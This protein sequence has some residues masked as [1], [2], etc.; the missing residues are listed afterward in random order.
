[1]RSRKRRLAC[2]RLSPAVHSWQRYGK[3]NA[4]YYLV[5]LLRRSFVFAFSIAFATVSHAAPWNRDARTPGE[6][7]GAVR[8]PTRNRRRGSSE[9]PSR[10]YTAKT[11]TNSSTRTSATTWVFPRPSPIPTQPLTNSAAY[12]PSTRKVPSPS[13]TAAALARLLADA[14]DTSDT[15]EVETLAKT[16]GNSKSDRDAAAQVF[17]GGRTRAGRTRIPKRR[18]STSC[19][20]AK[21]SP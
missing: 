8:C 3:V 11:K 9:S 10:I 4:V 14:S 2:R 20:H 1:M 5:M 13:L 12:S 7:L 21:L 6:K 15:S 16:Y 18:P 19:E 17:S